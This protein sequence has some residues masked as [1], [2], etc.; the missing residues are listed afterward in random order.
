M[1]N[2]PGKRS[3]ALGPEKIPPAEHVAS[4]VDGGR[5]RTCLL[6]FAVAGE[7]TV[8]V[9]YW[10]TVG[11]SGILLVEHGHEIGDA[12]ALRLSF[13]LGRKLVDEVSE[14]P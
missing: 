12:D 8:K 4:G 13:G 14:Y 3:P 7:A 5:Q 1:N 2:K 11:Q 10:R 9:K 6:D